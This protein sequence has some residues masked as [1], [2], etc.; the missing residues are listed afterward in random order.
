[1]NEPLADEGLQSIQDYIRWA[2]SRF[3]EAELFYGHGTDNSWDEAVQL[4]LQSLNLPWDFERNL[5]NCRL[6]GDEKRLL[7]AQISRR[8]DERV[9]VPYLVNKAWFC[10]LPFYVDE[11]VLIPRSP[12]AELIEKGFQPWLGDVQVNQ[13]LDLCCGSGCIGIACAY[14]WQDAEVDLADLSDEALQV[15]VINVDRHELSGRVTC[16]QSDLF[17][18]LPDKRYDLI[19]SN[20]PYV[21]LEDLADMPSEFEHE[22]ELG[23]ASGD[24]GLDLTWGILAAAANHLTD[25]GVLVVEV[26]NSW[27]ALQELLPEVAFNW[28]EFE[29]GG[30]GVFVLTAEQCREHQALFEKMH[31]HRAASK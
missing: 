7:S 25:E 10:D 26:G 14:A 3:N 22:P 27:V 9:P 2:Y 30:D 15:A 16:Y 5:M 18:A 19:V 23:L 29:L 8:I 13:I 24:D 31:Q 11:R 12:I 6:T 4:V 17:S 21:D 1:M 28:I 20:P